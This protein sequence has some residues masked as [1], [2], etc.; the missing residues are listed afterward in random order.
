[1]LWKIESNVNVILENYKNDGWQNVVSNIFSC[2][3][4]ME[5]LQQSADHQIRNDIIRFTK[6]N[7]SIVSTKSISHETDPFI[8]VSGIKKR[9][10]INS[11]S[12]T[13]QN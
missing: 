4:I 12:D 10:C 11:Q 6:S 1:M 8:W 9:T 7:Q 2:Y 3:K 13:S 5:D